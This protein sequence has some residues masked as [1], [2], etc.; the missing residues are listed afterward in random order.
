LDLRFSCTTAKSWQQSL[1]GSITTSYVISTSVSRQGISQ[2]TQ[3]IMEKHFTYLDSLG[4]VVNKSKTELM[5]MANMKIPVAHS[6]TVTGESFLG[7]TFDKGLKWLPH[8]ANLVK[9]SQRMISDPKIIRPKMTQEQFVKVITPQ[10]YKALY[11]GVPVW[12]D[13]L[14]KKDRLKMDVLHYNV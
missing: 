13:A 11:Q 2:E 4:M 3:T 5:I 6:I 10:Y 14:L 8:V 7:I 12:N 1:E 9:K